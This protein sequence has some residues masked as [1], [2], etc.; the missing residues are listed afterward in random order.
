MT[1]SEDGKLVPR[2][3]RCMTFMEKGVAV[4]GMAALGTDVPGR[5][6]GRALKAMES[7]WGRAGIH[8]P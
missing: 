8:I 3:K 4:E 6:G 7:L 1:Q 5:F 2:F